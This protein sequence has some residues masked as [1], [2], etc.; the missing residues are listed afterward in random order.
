MVEHALEFRGCVLL[1]E[2][3]KACLLWSH[4]LTLLG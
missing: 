2:N 4:L 1:W 3:L